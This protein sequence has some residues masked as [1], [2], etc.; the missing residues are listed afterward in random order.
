MLRDKTVRIC[1]SGEYLDSEK[2]KALACHP[3]FVNWLWLV[4]KVFGLSEH[5]HAEVTWSSPSGDDVSDNHDD[6]KKNEIM[7]MTRMTRN[8][9]GR[10]KR[11]RKRKLS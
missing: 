3:F 1:H 8:I 2:E 9:R 5:E 4:I 6:D 10:N 11:K 7:V